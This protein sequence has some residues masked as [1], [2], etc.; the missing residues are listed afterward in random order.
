MTHD[1]L[2]PTE[3]CCAKDEQATR[4]FCECDLI[5]RVRQDDLYRLKD[6]GLRVQN[7]HVMDATD[8]LYDPIKQFRRDV[9]IQFQREIAALGGER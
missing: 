7:E 9:W 3:Q 6:I 8:W 5:A 4:E 2:C 1:P